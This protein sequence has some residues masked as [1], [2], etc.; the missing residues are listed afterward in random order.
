MNLLSLYHNLHTQYLTVFDF[1]LGERMYKNKIIFLLSS[2]LFILISCGGGGGGGASNDGNLEN[3][4]RAPNA[5][6]LPSSLPT[7]EPTTDDSV[8]RLV[9]MDPRPNG[10]TFSCG[11]CHALEEP[12]P[13]QFD[14]PGHAVGDALRRPNFK[15][16]LLPN[17]VDAAN[18]CLETWM[19]VPTD[20][21]WTEESSDFIALTEFLRE[22]DTGQ[23]ES[24][25]LAFAK[26]EPMRF[27]NNSDVE[28]DPEAGREHFNE[29]CAICHGNNALGTERAPQLAGFYSFEGAADFISR[30]VR[31]SG[32]PNDD[33]YLGEAVPGVMP[34]WGEDRIS[35]D[36]LE[37]VIAFIINATAPDPA[38]PDPIP[39]PDSRTCA[40]T[41]PRIGQ[42]A[43][44]STIAHNVSGTAVIV[45]DCTIRIDNFS[46]DG[47]GINIRVYA[48]NGDFLTTGFSIS[49][50]LFGQVFNNDTL[51]VTIPEGR[52]LDDID[53]ISIWCI[54]VRFSFGD[55]I[56]Q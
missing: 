41:H 48:G 26:A 15:N 51:T 47:G 12:L 18:T 46:F 31:L 42:Q 27:A 44:L 21:L 28:G 53:R 19:T 25:T 3:V 39:T 56:F 11:L 23:G 30:K 4:N 29:S 14:R 50:D 1:L 24:P 7:A 5:T 10:N 33:I 8:G 32:P 43:E 52:T 16:G 9:F 55:G 35:D 40:S 6:P 36:D 49:D 37:D 38:D 13:D 34:F 54:P 45:D 2:L 17:F 20:E 22:Q